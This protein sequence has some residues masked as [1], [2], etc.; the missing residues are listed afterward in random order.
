[1]NKK[2]LILLNKLMNLKKILIITKNNFKKSYKIY[3]I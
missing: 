2:E 3:K 1:M